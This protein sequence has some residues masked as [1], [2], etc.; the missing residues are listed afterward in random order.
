MG[1]SE[2][3]HTPPNKIVDQHIPAETVDDVSS[4]SSGGS[5][6]PLTMSGHTENRS[7]K[8]GLGLTLSTTNLANGFDEQKSIKHKQARCVVVENFYPVNLTN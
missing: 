4:T 8:R 7:A 6:R 1:L 2:Q 3:Q 5:Y